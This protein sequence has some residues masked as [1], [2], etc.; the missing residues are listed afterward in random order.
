MH[1]EYERERE[2]K[3]EEEEEEDKTN[4]FIGLS[5]TRRGD[6]PLP[7]HELTVGNWQPFGQRIAIE[8]T[9]HSP[10]IVYPVR[11]VPFFGQEEREQ[12]RLSFLCDT[13]SISLQHK[14]L[15][16]ASRTSERRHTVGEHLHSTR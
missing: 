16:E 4:R 14:F 15:F 11:R 6:P 12:G 9:V 3:K 2:K 13:D 1:R 10:P 5:E 7:A 8:E